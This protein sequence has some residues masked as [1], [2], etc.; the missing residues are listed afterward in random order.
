M[1]LEGLTQ[2]FHQVHQAV[3]NLSVHELLILIEISCNA[4]GKAHPVAN[5]VSIA[6]Q[7]FTVE[8]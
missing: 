2:E 8:T 3:G 7:T 6:T 1:L 4:S 5:I